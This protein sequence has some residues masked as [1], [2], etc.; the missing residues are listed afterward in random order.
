MCYTIAK[1]F[2]FSAA[3]HLEGLPDGHPCSRQ[4]GHN[5]LV[6]VELSTLTLDE[7]GFVIDYGDLKPF[8]R[9]I[10]EHLDHRDLNEVVT[11]NPTAEN[12]AKHLFGI[13]KAMFPEVSAVRVSETPKTWAEYRPVRFINDRIKRDG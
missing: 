7:R 2:A 4:H 10:D 6:T 13:A 5:Y 12:L 8:Q 9:W 1:E 3:H 11:F